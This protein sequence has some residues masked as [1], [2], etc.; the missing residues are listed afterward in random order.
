[1]PQVAIGIGPFVPDAD[2]VLL[3]VVH[4]R[5]SPEE[6][7]QFVDNGFQVKL[8]GGQQGETVVEVEAHLMPEDAGCPRP[9]AVFLVDALGEDPVQ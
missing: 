6:P 2:A 5:V 4:I 8:L 7:K 1:M 3:E 9:R